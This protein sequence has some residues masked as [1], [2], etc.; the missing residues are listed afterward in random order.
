MV[1][2]MVTYIPEDGGLLGVGMVFFVGDAG[3][4]A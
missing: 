3:G 1:G 4:L 2:E